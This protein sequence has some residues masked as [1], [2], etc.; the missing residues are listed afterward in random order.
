VRVH[1][2]FVPDG[3]RTWVVVACDTATLVAKTKTVLQ[4]GAGAARLDAR[5]DLEELKSSREGSGGFISVM[6]IVSF[7]A[8]LQAVTD[9]EIDGVADVLQ[10]LAP[11]EGPMAYTFTAQNDGKLV[12]T[13]HLGSAAADDVRRGLAAMIH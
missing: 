2:L 1:L 8:Q 6:S 3:T 10:K 11:G 13:F 4:S 7:F 12:A 9:G 5:S